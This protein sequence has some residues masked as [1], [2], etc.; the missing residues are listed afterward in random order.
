MVEFATIP[1]FQ[2]LATAI[3]GVGSGVLLAGFITG[4]VDGQGR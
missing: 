1:L 2:A 4:H 3:A